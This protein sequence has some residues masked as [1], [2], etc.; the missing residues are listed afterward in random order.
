MFNHVCFAAYRA[1][2]VWYVECRTC[3]VNF[4]NRSYADRDENYFYDTKAR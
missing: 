2:T 4:G 3:M 1:N